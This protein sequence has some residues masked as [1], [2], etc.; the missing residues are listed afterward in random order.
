MA[1]I[2]FSRITPDSLLKEI[3][4][5][6]PYIRDLRDLHFIFLLGPTPTFFGE[7]K[8]TTSWRRAFIDYCDKYKE[9][10]NSYVIVLPEPKDCNWESVN[11]PK[12]KG[13]EHIYC[14]LHWEDYFINLAALNG[15][16]VSNAYFRWKGNAG[17]TA[18]LETGK[19]FALI[20]ESKVNAAVLNYPLNLQTAE[21]IEALY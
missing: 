1:L 14:Q 18:G 17:S 9:L 3:K 5:F 21:Y 15:V 8:A 12:L 2:V 7:N 4:N 10:N 16:L 11:Y 6:N 20:K 13:K 19:L